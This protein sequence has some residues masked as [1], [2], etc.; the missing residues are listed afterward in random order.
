MFNVR[1]SLSRLRQLS[2]HDAAG[3]AGSD[4]DEIDGLAWL[5]FASRQECCSVQGNKI[6]SSP[7]CAIVHS[8]QLA[9]QE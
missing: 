9:S 2:R 7:G 1:L 5:E 4:D 6:A 3:R 8:T